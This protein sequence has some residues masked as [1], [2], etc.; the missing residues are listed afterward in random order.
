MKKVKNLTEAEKLSMYQVTL[1]NAKTSEKFSIPLTEVG[2]SSDSIEEGIKLWETARKAVS[3]CNPK[4]SRRYE[5]H[6]VFHLLKAELDEKFQ[7]D[8]KKSRIIFKSDIVAQDKL[9][10]KKPY[11]KTY[12]KQIEQARLFYTELSN[13]PDLTARLSK[14]NYSSEETEARLSK[15]SEIE[16]ARAAYIY[17]KGISQNATNKKSEAFKI[18]DTWMNEFFSLA[19]IAFRKEPQLM[20]SLDVVVK[21]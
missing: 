17:E 14:R 15:I 9:G 11:Y 5:M 21:N 3:E 6:K 16:V 19:K 1:L 7:V 12:V 10:L 13:N 8:W 20:E 4:K 2:Y 18:L